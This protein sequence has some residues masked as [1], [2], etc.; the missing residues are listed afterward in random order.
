MS[1]NTSW[2]RYEDTQ[3]SA[4]FRLA[5]SIGGGSIVSALAT[6]LLEAFQLFE[7]NAAVEKGF[8]IIGLVGDR[9]VV[10]R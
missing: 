2:F 10:A 8:H 1:P 7:R 6:L 9:M 5:R 3:T 4:V